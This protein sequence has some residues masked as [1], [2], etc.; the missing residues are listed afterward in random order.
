MPD[1]YMRRYTWSWMYIVQVDVSFSYRW[2]CTT[3]QKS[4]EL[5]FCGAVQRATGLLRNCPGGK[6]PKRPLSS[7]PFVH[8][9]QTS[10]AGIINLYLFT[11]F[12][13]A[14]P[15]KIVYFLTVFI[16][17]RGVKPNAIF[18]LHKKAF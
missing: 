11:L 3:E 7:S 9:S 4:P 12:M 1:K 13:E 14:L 10:R 17:G 2:R 5:E 16:G 18:F 8:S 15:H 6:M